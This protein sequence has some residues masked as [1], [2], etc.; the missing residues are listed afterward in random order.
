MLAHGRA[1]FEVELAA[2]S[3]APLSCLSHQTPTIDPVLHAAQQGSEH[4]NITRPHSVLPAITPVFGSIWAI[5]TTII[6]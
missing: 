6:V 1:C 2:R 5:H 4:G 3:L